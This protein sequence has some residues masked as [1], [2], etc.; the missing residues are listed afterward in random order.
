MAFPAKLSE[1][2]RP[3]QANCH[4][5]TSV[6]GSIEASVKE[7]S[8]NDPIEPLNEEVDDVVLNDAPQSMRWLGWIGMGIWLA[9]SSIAAV[10]YLSHPELRSVKARLSSKQLEK[11]EG[12]QEIGI[13]PTEGKSIQFAKPNID[14]PTSLG[15]KTMSWTLLDGS[16]QIT[17][18]LHYPL[19]RAESAFLRMESRGWELVEAEEFEAGSQP[20]PVESTAREGL[21][22][23]AEQRV[24]VAYVLLD[25]RGEPVSSQDDQ[26]GRSIGSLLKLLQNG[27]IA[28]IFRKP[29]KNAAPYFLL[30]VTQANVTTLDGAQPEVCRSLLKTLV[31]QFTERIQGALGND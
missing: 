16:D 23:K 28:S 7:P 4:P 12:N 10:S 11:I 25:R 8:A 14:S 22:T 19:D 1:A 18:A 5:G 21:L 24:Y 26:S 9:F 27:P 17:I 2:Y 29:T 6:E 15:W 30:R 20:T 13:Q 3:N 31:P